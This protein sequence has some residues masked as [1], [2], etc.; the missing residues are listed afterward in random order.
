MLLLQHYEHFLKIK[1]LLTLHM[2]KQL[3]IRFSSIASLGSL[4]GFNSSPRNPILSQLSCIAL[5]NTA[6]TKRNL[7][8][9]QN[10]TYTMTDNIIYEISYHEKHGF[11]Q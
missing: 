3:P 7:Y 6:T 2:S 1:K 11:L 4:Y 9:L 10:K 8:S 5:Y